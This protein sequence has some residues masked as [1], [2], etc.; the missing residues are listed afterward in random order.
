M[1][2]RYVVKGAMVK[3]SS[4]SSPSSL[5]L[6]QSHGMYVN[7]KAVLNNGDTAAGANVMPFGK[8]KV[9]KG[10]CS[11]ALAPCWDGAKLNTL[12]EG[13]PTLLASSTLSCSIGGGITIIRDG[14]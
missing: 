10:P 3:C 7:E 5:N 9:L 14:Q 8:C 4:G 12:I 1:G 13:K 6:P 11:P 2:I